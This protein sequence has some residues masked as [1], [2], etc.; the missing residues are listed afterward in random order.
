[1][2]RLSHSTRR[3]YTVKQLAK[4]LE[5]VMDAHWAA[6]EQPYRVDHCFGWIR[7]RE[8]EYEAKIKNLW[9]D[10]EKKSKSYQKDIQAIHENYRGITSTAAEMEARLSMYK[11]DW[12]KAT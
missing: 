1:M 10:Q 6:G 7:V 3:K 12:E 8:D 2:K 4:H 5:R 9:S 11:N